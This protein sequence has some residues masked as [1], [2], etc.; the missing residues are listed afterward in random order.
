MALSISGVHLEGNKA[1]DEQHRQA[2][3][4]GGRPSPAMNEWSQHGREPVDESVEVE[5]E[6]SLA[7]ECSEE[8]LA[9]TDDH[10]INRG[11]ALVGINPSSFNFRTEAITSGRAAGAELWICMDGIAAGPSAA[12][13]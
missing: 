11:I 13:S 4:P 7:V 1:D 6:V 10:N 2:Q 12:G 3:N 5:V 8:V 9:G